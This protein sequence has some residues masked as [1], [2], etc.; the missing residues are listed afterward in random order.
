MGEELEW[1]P[2][3]ISYR[4][5][6]RGGDLLRGGGRQIVQI[7]A[8]GP[9]VVEERSRLA[10]ATGF[11]QLGDVAGRERAGVVAV[12]TLPAG[13]IE[14]RQPPE[15][16]RPRDRVL[17]AGATVRIALRR[18]HRRSRAVAFRFRDLVEQ[19]IRSVPAASSCQVRANSVG[20]VFAVGLFHPQQI[21]FLLV[22]VWIRLGNR[23]PLS[24][25][26]L[27]KLRILLTL[28]R[29]HLHACSTDISSPNWRREA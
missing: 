28:L 2:T 21:D 18:G 27:R 23:L 8:A 11:G 4:G 7:D 20:K 17:L 29:S 5:A 3:C 19:A 13:R 16:H 22:Q 12:R 24:R 6:E 1:I 26:R 9:F 15:M 14:G 25:W 10:A